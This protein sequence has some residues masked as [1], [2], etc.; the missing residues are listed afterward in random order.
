MVSHSL[1]PL[2]MVISMELNQ[3]MKKQILKTL[4]FCL[5]FLFVAHLVFRIKEIIWQLLFIQFFQNYLRL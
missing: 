2:Y 4:M 5:I 3:K 1:Q